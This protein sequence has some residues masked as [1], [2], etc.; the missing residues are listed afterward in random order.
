MGRGCGASRL[1]KSKEATAMSYI[2]LL[3]QCEDARGGYLYVPQCF[4]SHDAT[5]MV[6]YQ[7][8][9]VGQFS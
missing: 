7:T 1:K 6:Y 3:P 2:C 9:D 4:V 5:S 8:S